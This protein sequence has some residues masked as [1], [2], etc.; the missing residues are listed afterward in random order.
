MRM[1]GIQGCDGISGGFYGNQGDDRLMIWYPMLSGIA[2]VAMVV[3]RVLI[4][5]CCGVPGGC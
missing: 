3:A 4:G 5:G 1:E 2:A